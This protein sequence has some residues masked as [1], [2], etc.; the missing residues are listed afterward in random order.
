MSDSKSELS[1]IKGGHHSSASYY[2]GQ[3]NEKQRQSKDELGALLSQGTPQKKKNG[4]SANL[5]APSERQPPKAKPNP[6]QESGN[7]IWSRQE[8]LDDNKNKVTGKITKMDAPGIENAPVILQ[9]NRMPEDFGNDVTS[10]KL[11]NFIEMGKMGANHSSGVTVHDGNITEIAPSQRRPVIRQEDG[12]SG[13]RKRPSSAGVQPRNEIVNMSQSSQRAKRERAERMPVAP[14]TTSSER[15]REIAMPSPQFRNNMI[16]RRTASEVEPLSNQ[17]EAMSSISSCKLDNMPPPMLPKAPK[18]AKKAE[19]IVVGVTPRSRSAARPSISTKA[20]GNDD[21]MAPIARRRDSRG[22]IKSRGSSG[23]AN[24]KKATV[25]PP[26]KTSYKKVQS[27]IKDLVAKDRRNFGGQEFSKKREPEILDLEY[28]TEEGGTIQDDCTFRSKGEQ[29]QAGLKAKKDRGSGGSKEPS[30]GHTLEMSHDDS[31]ASV[32]S[33]SLLNRDKPVESKWRQAAK[34]KQKEPVDDEAEEGVMKIASNLLSSNILKR[35]NSPSG[36]ATDYS[37][38]QKQSRS[39]PYF[40]ETEDYP[41]QYKK[42][43]YQ[44]G[45]QEESKE[46]IRLKQKF[47]QLERN[48]FDSDEGKKEEF[49]K[50]DYELNFNETSRVSSSQF[51]A[52]CPNEDMK[53]FFKKEFDYRDKREIQERSPVDQNTIGEV[54]YNSSKLTYGPNSMFLEKKFSG[55]SHREDV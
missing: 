26:A 33:N 20:K 25:S 12:L 27:K 15:K 16:A 9:K 43:D 42:N 11:S 23:K 2:S 29:H 32:T 3:H 54:S 36:V 53:T 8:F 10:M 48:S 55:R 31:R 14:T 39:D 47:F 22:S 18:A 17:L 38:H 28:L 44:Y 21:E 1:S 30:G 35:F 52:F 40:S 49:N 46:S 6:N 34:T 37:S 45:A 41:Q 5:Y 24:D 4:S 19:L 51:S 7:G 13:Q 50:E